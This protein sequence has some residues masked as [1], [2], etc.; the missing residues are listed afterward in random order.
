MNPYFIIKL[1]IYMDLQKDGIT[2]AGRILDAI[3]LGVIVSL[4]SL[5]FI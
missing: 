5:L 2:E 3:V 4:S 1:I